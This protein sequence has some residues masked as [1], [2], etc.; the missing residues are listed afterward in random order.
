VVATEI[1]DRTEV[2]RAQSNIGANFMVQGDFAKARSASES[3][4]Q[5]A[6]DLGNQSGVADTLIN[7]GVISYDLGDVAKAGQQLNDALTIARSLGRRSAVASASAALG[8]VQLAGDNLTSAKNSFQ[9]S[10]DIRTQIGEKNGIASSQLQVATV[11][12]EEGALAQAELSARKAVQQFHDLED[13]DQEAGALALVGRILIA[14]TKVPDAQA[15]ISA[16]EKLVVRDPT[17]KI[18]LLIARS[19]VDSKVNSKAALDGFGRAIQNAVA[20]K[21]IPGELE[22]RVAR[23]KVLAVGGDGMRARSEQ[24]SVVAD[25]KRR[26]FWLLARKAEIGSRR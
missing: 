7:L 16:A 10:L 18:Q 8:D 17:T 13:P 1:G 19:E 5:T 14:Q 3:A 20:I 4:L 9:E 6:R 23:S 15:E 22:A 2:L 25:A 24:A 21:Y 11:E 12:L 26:G